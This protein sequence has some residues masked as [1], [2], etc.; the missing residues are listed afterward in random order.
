MTQQEIKNR[1]KQI[2][3]MIGFKNKGMKNL[4]YWVDGNVEHGTTEN[5]KFDSDWNWLMKAIDFIEN[6]YT[7]R[8]KVESKSCIL[9]NK[10]SDNICSFYS[11]VS[12]KEAAFITVSDFAKLYNEKKS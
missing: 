5:L 12:K 7:Y 11:S 3:L 9:F 6:I 4:E 8:V 2:A 1:N 10:N